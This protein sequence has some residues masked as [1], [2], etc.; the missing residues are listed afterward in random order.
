MKTTNEIRS[1]VMKAAWTIYR[2]YKVQSMANWSKA[3]KKAWKWAKENLYKLF[4]VW[5]PNNEMFRFYI[6]KNYIQ[7]N[8][9]ERNPYGYYENHR[10]CKGERFETGFYKLVGISKEDFN[11][12]YG[13][14]IFNYL[15]V[16]LV[17][18]KF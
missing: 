11:N 5:T 1:K 2:K 9:K 3:L 7:V 15:H 13:D 10:Y 8:I 4:N 17:P 16:D 14:A 18:S 6:G 12:I